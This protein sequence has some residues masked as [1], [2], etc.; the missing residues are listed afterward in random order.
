M[1][2]PFVFT[3]PVSGA[4]FLNRKKALRRV[5]TAIHQGGSV[6]VTG[7]PRMG[8]TS[9][10]LHLQTL[11]PRKF[12]LAPG[13]LFWRYLDAQTVAGWN[14]DRFWKEVFRP[15]AQLPQAQSAYARP[16]FDLAAWEAAL[17]EMERAGFRFVLLLDELDDLIQEPGLH[18][19]AVYG[20]LRSL[21]HRFRS[22]SVIAAARGTLTDL[23]TKTRDFTAGSPYFNF[24]V[25][26]SLG[27]LPERDVSRLLQKAGARFS[28]ADRRFL[29]RLAGR[30]PYFLQV[31]AHHLWESYQEGNSSPE[32][33][34]R[35]VARGF[36]HQAES[37]LDDIWRYWPPYVQIAFTL[38]GL[39]VMPNLLGHHTF[40][41]QGLM[42]IFPY[43]GGELA[44][45]EERGFLLRDERAPIGYRPAA[46]VM[47]WHLA[48]RLTVLLRPEARL[49]DWLQAQRWEGL[50][51]G[52]E[53]EALLRGIRGLGDLLKRGAQAFI[54]AAARG[55]AQGLLGR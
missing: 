9:L 52:E 16:D 21:A 10:L 11:P 53:K 42:D 36:Y 13:R 19:R 37:V 40:D 33:R 18:T 55:A 4:D 22:F 38:A 23:N 45:L 48:D 20:P 15:L 12:G 29:R 28:A 8:K 24:M 44:K 34:Y 47:V 54:E 25:Q 27:P 26:V 14:A 35:E 50:L 5:L 46:E 31:A 17:G 30:H 2:N 1:V 49:K 7:E 3:A 32:D 39:T 51:K 43:L 41:T 6:L